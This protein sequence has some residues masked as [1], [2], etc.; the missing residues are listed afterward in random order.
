MHSV[1]HVLYFASLQ[2]TLHHFHTG[3]S[4]GIP[5]MG[6]HNRV[7]NIRLHTRGTG[8]KCRRLAH[9]SAFK[10]PRWRQVLL[11]PYSNVSPFPLHCT[12]LRRSSGPRGVVVVRGREG[13]GNSE[14]RPPHRHL[15]TLRRIH[16]RTRGCA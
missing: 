6:L 11:A 13:G 14:F 1:L 9:R 12:T 5:S 10:C 15:G 2:V 4:Y 16:M 7:G 3:V 8:V